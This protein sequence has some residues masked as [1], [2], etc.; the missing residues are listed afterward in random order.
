M[1][2]TTVRVD[3]KIKREIAAL[4][5]RL[6][7]ATGRKPSQGELVERAVAFTRRNEEAF[8]EEV[9]GVIDLDSEPMKALRRHLA[10]IERLPRV[11]TDVA[12]EID[13]VVYGRQRG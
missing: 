1:A 11:A 6:A 4:Q 9:T 13:D 7:K 10:K 5:R 8:L 3:A 2:A 12:T